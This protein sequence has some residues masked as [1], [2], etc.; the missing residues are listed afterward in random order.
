MSPAQRPEGAETR[1]P[2]GRRICSPSAPSCRC[3]CRLAA[4][5]TIP[6]ASS[7]AH[8]LLTTL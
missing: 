2:T 8:N 7:R 4:C 3:R 1:E 5:S 6:P